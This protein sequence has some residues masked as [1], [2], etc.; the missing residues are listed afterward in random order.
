MA[1]FVLDDSSTSAHTEANVNGGLIPAGGTAILYNGDAVSD[2]DFRAA[3]GDALNLVA[4]T[5]WS[6]LSLNNSGDSVGLWRNFADY[7][8][9]HIIHARAV[10]SLTFDDGGEW[11]RTNGSASIYLR[12]LTLDPQ[13]GAHW[14]LSLEDADTP[15][16]AAYRSAAAGGNSGNDIGSPD[17]TAPTPHRPQCPHPRIRPTRRQP[18]TPTATRIHGQPRQP[19]PHYHAHAYPNTHT[20]ST[21]GRHRPRAPHPPHAHPR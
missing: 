13:N 2:T 19:A 18:R 7:S 17:S 16:G 9:D 3:W 5:G 15:T 4:V 14:A 11:P 1:G 20:V 6:R 21:R 10:V 12:D 8:G